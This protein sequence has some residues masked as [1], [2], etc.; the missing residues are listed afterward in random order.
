MLNLR[1]L[2]ATVLLFSPAFAAAEEGTGNATFMD[3]IRL[4]YEFS[5]T[6]TI[7]FALFTFIMLF[8]FFLTMLSTRNSL[9]APGPLLRNLLDDIA[10]KDI[11][12]AQKRAQESPTLLG[13]VV[14]PGLRLHEHPMD[15]IQQ[16]MEGAG[17]RVIGSL[18]TRIKILANIG[19]LSP[20]LG[21]LGTVLGLMKAF[22]VMGTEEIAQGWKSQMM[23]SAIGEA[24]TTTAL[25]LIVGIPAMGAYYYCI[26][27]LGRVS[28]EIEIGSEEIAAAISEMKT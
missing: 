11:E 1:T 7:I 27:R 26:S 12:A 6:I 28:D 9:V 24:M 15:R 18:R 3:M 5:P 8:I 2:L 14:L 10:S 25:G 23:T 19:V 17:R 4:G 20:M 22:N 16:A 21:L 13:R